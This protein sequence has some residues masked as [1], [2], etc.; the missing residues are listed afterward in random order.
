M[1]GS[2]LCVRTRDAEEE[3]SDATSSTHMFNRHTDTNDIEKVARGGEGRKGG[4]EGERKSV[5]DERAINSAFSIATHPSWVFSVISG[6]E[7]R[8]LKNPESP[9][10]SSRSQLPS[11]RTPWPRS[12]RTW[13]KLFQEEKN[14]QMVDAA[15]HICT[16]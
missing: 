13:N 4:R 5:R 14:E 10:P 11:S 15:V 16:Q 6:A 9:C 2:F 12:V 3:E 1:S 7:M 8:M